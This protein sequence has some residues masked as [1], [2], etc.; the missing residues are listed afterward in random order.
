[1]QYIFN[2]R[3]PS[4][5]IYDCQCSI[6]CL[7]E[8]M[9]LNINFHCLSSKHIKQ[10]TILFLNFISF[11]HVIGN[12]FIFAWYEYRQPSKPLITEALVAL[13][14]V[15]EYWNKKNKKNVWVSQWYL[16]RKCIQFQLRCFR[17]YYELMDIH[18]SIY[19]SCCIMRNCYANKILCGGEVVVKFYV[20][21]H[22][23]S[24]PLSVKYVKYHAQLLTQCMNECY[25]AFLLN[26]SWYETAFN[27]FRAEEIN[28]SRL[29]TRI[30]EALIYI[31]CLAGLWTR[32]LSHLNFYAKGHN[33]TKMVE[34]LTIPQMC[35]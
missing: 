3:D 31:I 9:H 23:F 29:I 19:T 6:H 17:I 25:K 8:I 32:R 21:L 28:Y 5:L 2:M 13:L 7:C 33:S 14:N 26:D 4:I 24:L 11:A 20:V 30:C 27:T 1:M 16:K 18:K 10:K 22:F 12:L 34:V 15:T 35:D